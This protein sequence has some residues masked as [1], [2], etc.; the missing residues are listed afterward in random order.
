MYDESYVSM[1][2]L[3]TFELLLVRNPHSNYFM[4]QSVDVFAMGLNSI[5]Y[6]EWLRMKLVYTQNIINQGNKMKKIF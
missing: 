6:Y 5:T 2:E 3:S 1:A 4:M